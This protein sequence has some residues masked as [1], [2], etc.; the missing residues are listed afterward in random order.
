[1]SQREHLKA[2]VRCWL[3]PLATS[4]T[5]TV[6]FENQDVTTSCALTGVGQTV[7]IGKY[8]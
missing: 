4:V 6:V 1:M 2:T 5:A 3:D 8:V 7:K